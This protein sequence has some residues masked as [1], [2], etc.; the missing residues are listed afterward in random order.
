MLA[1]AII[2][3]RPQLGMNIGMVARAMANFALDDL[4]LVAP[5]D[6]WPNPDAG[7]AAAGADHVLERTTVYEDVPAALADCTSVFA[8][9]VRPRELVKPVVSP[10]AAVAEIRRQ[11]SRGLRSG[12]LFGPERSGLTADDLATTG[13]II[14]CPVN[15]DFGSLNLAQAVLLV[16]YEHFQADPPE[17]PTPAGD[18]PATHGEVSGLIGHLEAELE[19]AGYFHVPERAPA[20]KRMLAHLL[21]RHGF[22]AQEIRTLRGI[23][24]SLAEHRQRRR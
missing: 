3:V 15:P 16:A 19:A 4:R 12:I 2:L 5:R 11:S 22:A 9:T 21:S 23:I 7:P 6:G 18:P 8:T 24:R 13:A 17:T 14:T 20:T 1:P 10:R